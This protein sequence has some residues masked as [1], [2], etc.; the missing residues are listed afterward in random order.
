MSRAGEDRAMKVGLLSYFQNFENRVSD[1]ELVKAQVHLALLAEPLGYDMVAAVEHHF[2]DYAMCP[3]NIQFLSY[4]AAK[5]QRIELLTT[6]VILPW[7]DP[8]RVA[9]KMIFL[10]HLSDGRAAFG[11]GRG[12][13]KKE[14]D[15]F[16][17]DMNE[18]RGR[19]DEAAELAMRALETGIAQG[20]GPY[21]K[22]PA[23]ELR[24][25][26]Y[27]S[28]ADRFYCVAMSSDSVPVCARLGARI[29]TFSMKPW[30][31]MKDHYDLH[32]RL[33]EEHHARPAPP[34]LICVNTTCD[35]SAEKA[36]AMAREHICNVYEMTMDHYELDTDRFKG[37]KGY[38]EYAG[39]AAMMKSIARKDAAN[40]FAD[41]NFWG[42]P[43]QILDKI[44]DARSHI[45]DFDLA[46][47]TIFGGMP[48]EAAESSQRLF[49]EKVLPELK[50]W[51]KAA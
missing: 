49:A 39:N 42:T 11:I 38:E 34:P 30:P 35:E 50:S 16:G 48:I 45:G 15:A 5:T 44:Y 37:V 32:R 47:Q 13:A 2:F 3:D 7:N 14:Y 31:L 27:K 40:A 51:K 23:I 41:V 21:Y 18:S 29:V 1:H 20:D 4:I 33:F 22:Q 43:Q 10:D 8:L 25:R 9:E 36:E 28:F 19:F 12:L 24:P 17:L 6:A 46:I 26:P